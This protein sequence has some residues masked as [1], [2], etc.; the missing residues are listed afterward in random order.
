MKTTY[1]LS[2]ADAVIDEYA[3]AIQDKGQLPSKHN[4]IWLEFCLERNGM[5][6][7]ARGTPFWEV[8]ALWYA[9][10]I[11]TKRLREISRLEKATNHLTLQRVT[12]EQ[13]VRRCLNRK[14]FSY[15][16]Q[17]AITLREILDSQKA[18]AA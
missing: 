6:P 9:C 8:V 5:I 10:L 17:T 13:V 7:S 14:A 1:D 18:V 16:S 12:T 2:K 11:V 3:A 15:N 4:R